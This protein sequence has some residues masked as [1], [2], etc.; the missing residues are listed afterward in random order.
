MT[1]RN[2]PCPCGSGK[3]FKKCCLNKDK[4]RVVSYRKPPPDVVSAGL[5]QIQK[6]M[7]AQ[8]EWTRQYGHVRPCITMDFAGRKFVAAGPRLYW[9]SQEHPWKYIPDFLQD[10]IPNVFGREWGEAEL[11]KPEHERHPLVQWRVEALKYMQQQP[12]QPNGDYVATPNGFLAAYMAFAF[13]LFAIEDNS[14]F[15]D[16]LLQRLKN[17]Q[18]F[19]GARHEVFVEAT[20]LRA[21]FSI[22]HE[23]E[24]DGSSR[25]AEF[26]AKHKATVQLVSIEAKSKHREGVLGQPGSPQPYEKLS[27]RFGKLLNDAI[28]KNPKHPLVVFID[29]NL[30]YRSAERVLGHDPLDVHKP[31]RTM[32]EL[33]DRDRRE[34]GGVDCYAMLVFTNHPHHYAQ[35]SELDP[36]KHTLSIIP[37]APVNGVQHWQALESLRYAVELYGRIPKEFPPH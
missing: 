5:L 34:H 9:S 26:T 8:Q 10:Y 15:D 4:L 28:A 18:Q 21:G 2:D 13:N 36:Q 35:P 23:N 19:Q 16:D 1:G 29:T 31:M 6:K 30:P 11:A 25:H 24:R 20:C 3:K 32:R 22:E 37:L 27:L 7:Q 33:M 14:R 17:K 12:R